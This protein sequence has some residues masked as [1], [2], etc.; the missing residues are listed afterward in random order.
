MEIWSIALIGMF[1]TFL[2]WFITATYYPPQGDEISRTS[3]KTYLQNVKISDPKREHGGRKKGEGISYEYE[4]KKVCFIRGFVTILF[5]WCLGSGAIYFSN[6][7]KISKLGIIIW[8]V[9]F[10]IIIFFIP[11]LGLWATYQKPKGGMLPIDE[12]ARGYPL[13]WLYLILGSCILAILPDLPFGSQLHIFFT[14]SISDIKTIQ[15]IIGG[16]LIPTIG[17][18]YLPKIVPPPKGFDNIPLQWRIWVTIICVIGFIF[19]IILLGFVK[20]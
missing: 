16:I 12:V 5:T 19:S 6:L 14:K 13:L 20:N 17:L 18:A 4:E 9:V 11:I 10:S 8:W 1:F 7:F 15:K 2:T 3:W